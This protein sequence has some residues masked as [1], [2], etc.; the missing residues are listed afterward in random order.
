MIRDIIRKKLVTLVN[1]PS[2]DNV[3]NILT[4]A[5]PNSLFQEDRERLLYIKVPSIS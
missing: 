1:I 2:K 3:A 5:K 4:K